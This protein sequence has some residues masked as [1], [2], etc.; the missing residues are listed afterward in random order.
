MNDEPPQ[1]GGGLR[2]ELSCAE[3]GRVQVTVDY[4]SATDRDS[5]DS[6][7]TYMLARSPA[8]GELQRAGLSVDKFSQ[9]DLLQGHVYYVHT[10]ERHH[11][12]RRCVHGPCEKFDNSISFVFLCL[13]GEIGPEPVFDT[14]TL[15]ISDGEAGG[16]E[17]CCHGD[18]PPPPVPLH[19]TLPVYDLN[20]TVL[21]VNNKV[22]AIILGK[23][24]SWLVQ[25][26]VDFINHIISHKI[27][28]LG[29]VVPS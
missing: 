22:P 28:I 10:G 17:G 19:G 14:V 13:G 2:G 5:D 16:T 25:L 12:R 9:Q 7:L 26:H 21:P 20:I 1:L 18:A 3:G 29:R 11:G 15:I 4:L 23:R 8:R 27:I 6:R 24:Q